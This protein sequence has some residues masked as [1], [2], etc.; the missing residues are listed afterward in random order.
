VY[1]VVLAALMEFFIVIILAAFGM[2]TRKIQ[3]EEPNLV[4]TGSR[5]E[6]KAGGV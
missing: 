2:V 3:L 5:E 1:R 6:I 4:K